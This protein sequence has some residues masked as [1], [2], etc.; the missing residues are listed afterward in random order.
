MSFDT[1]VSEQGPQ[2]PILTPNSGFCRFS[3]FPSTGLEKIP[4]QGPLNSMVR[5]HAHTKVVK[6]SDFLVKKWTKMVRKRMPQRHQSTKLSFLT[7]L[8]PV[9]HK[10]ASF[11]P[12]FDRKSLKFDHFRPFSGHPLPESGPRQ[13]ARGLDWQG[14][15]KMTKMTIFD[16]FTT[17]QPETGQFFD[18]F[19]RKITKNRQKW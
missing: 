8:A 13:H 17:V 6:N 3:G 10:W 4:I 12:F 9:S 7:V 14:S 18:P 5:T 11:E 19:F 1:F 15:Q 2:V 16:H